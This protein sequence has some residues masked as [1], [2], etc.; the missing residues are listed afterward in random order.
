[1][2]I[3]FRLPSVLAKAAGGQTVHQATGTTVGEIVDDVTTRHPEL[4]RRLRD[5]EGKPYPYVTFYVDDEDIR[6][7]RG[8]DTPVAEG[9]EILVVPAIAGG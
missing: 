8:F 3:T 5:A 2:S 4:A 9:A 1:M 6:F 7:H